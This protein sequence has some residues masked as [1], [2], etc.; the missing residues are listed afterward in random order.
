[1][2][3]IPKLVLPEVPSSQWDAACGIYQC[4]GQT[5]FSPGERR[6]MKAQG[7]SEHSCCSSWEPGTWGSLLVE[8]CQIELLHFQE[9]PQ[10]FTQE[11]HWS[12]HQSSGAV[13]ISDSEGLFS[14]QTCVYPRTISNVLL[15]LVWSWFLCLLHTTLCGLHCAGQS[16]LTSPRG[17]IP[18]QSFLGV[19]LSE[20][21]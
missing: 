5:S 14:L 2:S 6:I 1:M 12:S 16:V 18:T 11:L 20:V 8:H 9:M 17:E 4:R 15:L 13:A 10:K 19:P 21:K 3:Y 7:A